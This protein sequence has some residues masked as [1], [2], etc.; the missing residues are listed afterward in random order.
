MILMWSSAGRVSR[1]GAAG[2][3]Y[4]LAGMDLMRMR[5]R[6]RVVELEALLSEVVVSSGVVGVADGAVFVFSILESETRVNGYYNISHCKASY[7]SC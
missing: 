3:T 1:V 2:E 6:S 5:L 7:L 4:L